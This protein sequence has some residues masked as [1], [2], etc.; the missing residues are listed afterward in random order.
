MKR[1]IAVAALIAWV[2]V[3][4]AVTDAQYAHTSWLRSWEVLGQDG[5]HW[6]KWLMRFYP[7]LA[8]LLWS[9]W[10]LWRVEL[11]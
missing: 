2:C 11:D 10:P 1:L 3:G 6:V 8:Y 7:L 4:D 5:Y 9:Q